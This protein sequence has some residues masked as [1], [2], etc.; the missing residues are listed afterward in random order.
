[1]NNL[2]SPEISTWLTAHYCSRART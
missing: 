1:M 2:Y